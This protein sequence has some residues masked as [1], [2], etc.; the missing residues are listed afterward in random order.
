[1]ARNVFDPE[2]LDATCEALAA[3]SRPD[4]KAAGQ[5]LELRR[6]VAECDRKLGRYREALAGDTE[7]TVI[8]GWIAET[9]RERENLE[10]Q[11]A[12]SSPSGEITR[13]EARALVEA[14]DDLTRAIADASP[15]DKAILY[16]E[17]GIELTYHPD[18]RVLVE[19]RPAWANERVGGGT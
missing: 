17:L 16:R 3:A 13:N 15:A 1:M 6:R 9:Q 2:N 14:V 11:L 12:A 10:R 4:S 8:A 7:A 18:G 19:A 5:A